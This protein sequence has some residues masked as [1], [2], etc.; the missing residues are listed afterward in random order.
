MSRRKRIG[1]RLGIQSDVLWK[2]RFL[3]HFD[4]NTQT[5]SY[6][7]DSK[8]NSRMRGGKEENEKKGCI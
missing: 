6:K 1:V 3:C 5:K 4:S 8:A 7:L 2:R